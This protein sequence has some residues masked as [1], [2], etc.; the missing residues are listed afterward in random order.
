M[1]NQG[2]RKQDWDKT[3]VTSKN[4]AREEGPTF[5]W[6]KQKTLAFLS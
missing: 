5:S 3:V 4:D 1:Q 6:N 2:K